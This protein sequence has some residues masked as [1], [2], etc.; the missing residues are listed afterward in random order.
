[1]DPL[2]AVVRDDA[3]PERNFGDWRELANNASKIQQRINWN[4]KTEKL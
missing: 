3:F 4:N 2:S 1:M